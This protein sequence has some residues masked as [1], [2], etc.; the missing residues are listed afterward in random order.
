M[1]PSDGDGELTRAGDTAVREIG[2]DE[3]DPIGTLAL[4]GIYF[5]ILVL[6]WLFMY[7]VEF[8][9]NEPTVIGGAIATLLEVML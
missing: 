1:N 5:L 7:F 6:M 9:G 3:F 2:H 4:I 8:I